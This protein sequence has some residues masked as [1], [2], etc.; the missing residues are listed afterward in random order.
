MHVIDRTV[1]D[2]ERVGQRNAVRLGAVS[3][4]IL[5]HLPGMGVALRLGPAA[6][7]RP[8]VGIFVHPFA[9]RHF[10]EQ[11]VNQVVPGVGEQCRTPDESFIV[12]R[13]QECR[14]ADPV[15]NDAATVIEA[16][17][18][19]ECAP[20]VPAVKLAEGNFPGRQEIGMHGLILSLG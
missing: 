9:A 20:A 5:G 6:I 17:L 4:E 7:E 18:Q 2:L 14:A 15:A 12:G 11:R 1:F 16:D 8:F 13:R 19:R 3:G 10:R